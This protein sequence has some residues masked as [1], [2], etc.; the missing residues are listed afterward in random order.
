MADVVIDLELLQ[1][2]KEDLEAIAK[3]FADADDFSDSVAEATGHDQ[4]SSHVRD[5]AHKWNDK[6][7]K[8]TEDVEG[9]QKSI[10][11]ISDGF[12]KVDDGLAKALEQGAADTKKSY[13][14]AVPK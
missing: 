13:P 7:K 5:F 11:A 2:L 10:A 3:E 8:M 12:T 4:L 9:L 6:R 1:Q 14:T